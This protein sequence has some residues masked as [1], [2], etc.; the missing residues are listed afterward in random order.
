MKIES[1]VKIKHKIPITMSTESVAATKTRSPAKK[2]GTED[3]AI[4]I[5]ELKN[6]SSIDDIAKKLNRTKGAIRMRIGK[7]VTN[8]Y[9]SGSD[10]DTIVTATTLD[11]EEVKK[12]IKI[13]DTKKERQQAK[14]EERQAQ[15]VEN[16][17]KMKDVDY[18]KE[19]LN[20]LQIRFIDI[21]N[22]MKEMSKL[23]NA[24]NK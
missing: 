6:N 19:K 24:Q 8:M 17:E 12:I 10:V 9:K 3:D 21:V 4:I 2:W 22:E 5:A 18:L 15:K 23:I 11:I 1:G 13:F 14:K 20:D 7:I 16:I